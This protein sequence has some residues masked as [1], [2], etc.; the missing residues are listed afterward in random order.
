V[1]KIIKALKDA[2]VEVEERFAAPRGKKT[3][4]FSL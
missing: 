3:G 2:V 4:K 1:K